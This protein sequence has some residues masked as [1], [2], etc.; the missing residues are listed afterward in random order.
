[1]IISFPIKTT[2]DVSNYN[3]NW[4]WPTTSELNIGV[5]IS[6]KELFSS[7]WRLNLFDEN[8]LKRNVEIKLSDVNIQS[9]LIF[10][11]DV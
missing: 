10:C 2:I 4:K 1:M 11:H 5:D 7:D 8:L 6:I 3:P 9:Q